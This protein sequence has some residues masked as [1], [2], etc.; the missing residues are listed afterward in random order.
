MVICRI[1]P[2]RHPRSHRLIFGQ[3]LAS[4][5]SILRSIR[6]A[7]GFVIGTPAAP[8]QALSIVLSIRGD[9]IDPGFELFQFLRLEARAHDAQAVAD[10]GTDLTIDRAVRHGPDGFAEGLDDLI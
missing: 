6:E 5:C 7:L 1:R 2:A 3:C 10:T 4:S 8:N 9:I